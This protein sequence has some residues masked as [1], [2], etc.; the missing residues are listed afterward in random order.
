[1]FE[2]IKNIIIDKDF[3]RKKED[4]KAYLVNVQA[5]AEKEQRSVGGMLITIRFV[6]TT[7]QFG[8]TTVIEDVVTFDNYHDGRGRFM[9]E[10]D[11]SLFGFY[12]HC[13]DYPLMSVTTQW[14]QEIID[15]WFVDR[16]I[17]VGG[18]WKDFD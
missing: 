1:M 13:E 10:Y 9:Y 12:H 16:G 8:K 15:K 5:R 6:K 2:T 11:P 3:F 18:T 17:V 7:K 14:L 4:V